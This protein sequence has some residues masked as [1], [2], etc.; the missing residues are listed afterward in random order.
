MWKRKAGGEERSQRD[1]FADGD[2]VTTQESRVHG[3]LRWQR[4]PGARD[5]WHAGRQ[6]SPFSLS[7][8][9]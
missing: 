8:A 3:G 1:S 9:H 6:G 4:L 2:G 7:L 5:S